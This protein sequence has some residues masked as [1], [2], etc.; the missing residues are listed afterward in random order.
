MACPE[1]RVGP[2]WE[3]QFAVNHL[4]HF[5]LT[6]ELTPYL[7][8]AGGA[9]VIVTS[10]VAHKRSQIRWDDVHFDK[11]PYDKWLAY[12]QSK[13]A[14]ALF[15]LELNNRRSKEGVKAFSVHPGPVKTP[16]MRHLD[17]DEMVL[18]GWMTPEGL[19]SE[20]AKRYVKSPSQGAASM[21]WAATS[22]LLEARGGEYI[23]DCD[24]AGMST[25][26]EPRWR[27]VA[28]WAVDDAAAARL[29]ELSEKMVLSATA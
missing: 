27:R 16:L 14:N 5:V 18:M 29:W 17:L 1:K 11:E 24:I 9:R 21:L 7:L 28:K 8:N 19:L 23:E 10:S 13:T 20:D 2:G 15:A 25:P 4:G 22:P 12:G 26:E 6:R 3:M